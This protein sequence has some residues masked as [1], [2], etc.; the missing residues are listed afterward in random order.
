MSHF[1]FFFNFHRKLLN[2][3]FYEAR[4]NCTPSEIKEIFAHPKRNPGGLALTPRHAFT[5]FSNTHGSCVESPVVPG[6][7]TSRNLSASF[8]ESWGLNISNPW[9]LLRCQYNSGLC[10]TA[11]TKQSLNV[12]FLSAQ[13]LPKSP[14]TNHAL[15][16]R[17]YKAAKAPE[18]QRQV[19]NVCVYTAI[20]VLPSSTWREEGTHT[21][22]V[23]S[24]YRLLQ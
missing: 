14:A 23:V 8:V 7:V 18:V 22:E 13:F 5:W 15:V 21:R 10:P 4:V 12:N 24:S 9:T 16:W 20:K 11:S 2:P 17:E 1:L 6:Q 19:W 3:P